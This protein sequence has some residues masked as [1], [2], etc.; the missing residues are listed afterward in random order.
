[1][2]S[3]NKN[4]TMRLGRFL[5]KGHTVPVA[6]LVIDLVIFLAVT[7][8]INVMHNFRYIIQD[9]ENAVDYMGIS[10][11]VP[12]IGR[13]LGFYLLI[14]LVIGI[15]DIFF[16]YQLRTSLGEAD[17]NNGTK[18]TARYT[19]QLEVREQYKAVPLKGE[20]YPGKG[21]TIVQ[22]QKDKLYIDDS[23]S[24]TLVIGTTRSGK[25]EMYVVPTIDVYSRAEKLEDRPSMIISDPKPELYKMCK[26]KLEERG[27]IVRFLNLADPYHSMG[28]NPLQLVINYYKTGDI[29]KAQMMAKTYSF[30]IFAAD[31]NSQEAIWKNTATDLYTAL[32]IAVTTD[33][34]EEDRELN[35]QR[36]QSWIE[37]RRAFMEL[38]VME[39]QMAR[40]KFQAVKKE[41]KDILSEERIYYI[42]PE[43][44]YF[45]VYPNE[46]NVNSFSCLNFFRELCDR[47]ALDAAENEEER[48]KLADTALDEY[49]NSRPPLDFAK[50]LYQEIKTAGDRTKGSVYINMQSALS[51][52]A[53]DSIARLTAE[54][55]VDIEAIGYGDRPIA[56][57]I[58]LPSEDRSNH[59]LVTTFIAQLYQRLF[60]LTKSREGKE[61]G[62]LDRQVKFILDEFGSFPEIENFASFVTVCLGLGISFDIYVQALNQIESKYKDDAKTIK[63]NFAN[64]VYIM[65]I[66]EDTAKE[67]SEMLGNRTVI[68]VQRSGS[69]LGLNKTFTE[70]ATERPLMYHDELSTLREGECVVYRGIKRTDR[71]G[72][73]VRSYPIINEYAD[74]MSILKKMR[75]FISFFKERIIQ[76][77]KYKH[78]DENEKRD[79]TLLEEWK[80]RENRVLQRDG[81]ALLYRYQY[82][83]DDF[84]D[85]NKIRIEDVN[86]ESR[87]HVN[88]RDMIVDPISMLQK[89]VQRAEKKSYLKLKEL[90]N[91]SDFCQLLNTEYGINWRKRLEISEE[92]TL[93]RITA[94]IC[95]AEMSEDARDRILRAVGGDGDE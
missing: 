76:G 74:G 30:S 53:L 1:M 46:K 21:G 55:D 29:A 15:L 2:R 26:A 37:K 92:D 5:A 13:H 51:V 4:M 84:P 44:L 20:K 62:K 22:R 33:C 40:E 88:Y 42:P 28:Y 9:M 7:Y 10:C 82:L 3:E 90:K 58:G 32:I 12:H 75:T 66:G 60:Q 67:F 27:Y 45:E 87:E 59:F 56:I 57:F 41:S 78:P 52:F 65:S 48:A 38:S 61:Q 93:S 70:T 39:Q 71:L 11:L 77:K 95:D 80:I 17:I 79:C 81:T 72:R 64:Q 83:S 23:K 6:V 31:N 24:N 35:E 19:T 16:A 63:E 47:K 91:Y 18:G 86:T 50:S 89:S 85:P 43:Q 49:F 36:R 14:M 69:R 8:L 73:A 68:E 54:N 25:G 34:L 94:V